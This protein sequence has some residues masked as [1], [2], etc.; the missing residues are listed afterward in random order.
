MRIILAFA[1]LMSAGT[2][3]AAH[4]AQSIINTCWQGH[5]HAGMSA[6]VADQ[7]EA[8]LRDLTKTEETVRLSIRTGP[9]DPGF[10]TYQTDA[11]EHLDA[12][13]DAFKLYRT[14]H[15]AFQAAVAAKGNG[16][17]DV[18]RACEAVLNGERANELRSSKPWLLLPNHGF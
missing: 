7:A 11:I 17:E 1:L 6:C 16:A 13:N 4:D 3:F 14:E 2:A 10:P 18:R 5:D 15:C 12:A 8:S 9:Y